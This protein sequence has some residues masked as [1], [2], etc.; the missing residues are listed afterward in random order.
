[1]AYE[2]P[3]NLIMQDIKYKYEQ[4][5]LIAI[6]N[7]GVDVN[8]YELIKALAYDRQQYSKGYQEGY[9]QAVADINSQFTSIHED[10]KEEN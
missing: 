2:S 4:N 7:V 3:I 8:R 1:M 5:I 10:Q 6:Q 9:A